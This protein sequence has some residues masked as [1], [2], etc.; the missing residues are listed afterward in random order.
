MMVQILGAAGF[1][2]YEVSN[3]ARKG[4]VARHNS[5]YWQQ[6]EYLG[7]GPSA[8]S[9]NGVS[10]QWNV[11]N[12][13]RYIDGVLKGEGFFEVEELSLKDRYNEYVMTRLRTWW[14]CDANEI[15]QLFGKNFREAFESEAEKKAIFFTRNQ[16][17]FILNDRGKLLADG[18]ASDFFFT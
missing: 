5:S 6:R 2:Q 14:G 15:E 17:S 8:H 3:F 12:N 9:Y 4:H 11:M 16:D 1:D 18:I 7:L 10:R 13:T